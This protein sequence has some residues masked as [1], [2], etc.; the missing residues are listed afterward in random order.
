MLWK[1]KETGNGIATIRKSDLSQF[2][3]YYICNGMHIKAIIINN[4]KEKSFMSSPNS[5]LTVH[6]HG[7]VWKNIKFLKYKFYL[8]KIKEF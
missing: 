1:K 5:N 7:K 3:V 8:V 6:K 4:N 2:F